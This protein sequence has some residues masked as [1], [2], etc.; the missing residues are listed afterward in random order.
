MMTTQS[1]LRAIALGLALAVPTGFSGS[2]A[3]AKATLRWKF[4]EGETLKYTSNQVVSTKILDPDGKELKQTTS[5]VI[6]MTWKVKSVEASTGTAVMTQTIDRI[7]TTAS[8]PFGKF[9]F[10]SKEAAE[11]PGPAASLFKLVGAEFTLKMN[12]RGELSEIKLPEKLL[13]A[14]QAGQDQAGSQVPY[15]E[16]GLKNM[17]VTT[18]VLLPEGP[19]DPGAKWSRKLTIPTG[20]PDQ[21]RTIEQVY[22]YTGPGASGETIE[23]V[24]AFDAPKADPSLPVSVKAQES[25]AKIDFDATA[26]RLK[27]IAAT[28]HIEVAGKVMDKDV[29]Q[30]ND[31]TSTLTLSPAG[32]P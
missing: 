24:T 6:D 2:L 28:E 17:L 4:Q 31:T 22:T 9:S 25:K 19:V 10:D 15:S 27:E 7:R 30:T 3:E 32:T 20:G 26:G 5:L 8:L 29:V 14:L 12:P 21:T 13:S 11:A 23:L 18:S 16:E 1:T